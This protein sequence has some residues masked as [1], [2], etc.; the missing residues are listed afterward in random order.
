MKYK[1]TKIDDDTTELSYKDKKF[2]IKKDVE[3]LSKMESLPRRARIKMGSDLAK[4]GM[5]F[6]DLEVEKK[7]GNKT[8]IDKSTLI[9]TERMYQDLIANE[10]FSEIT[11]KYTNMSFIELLEDIEINV[12]ELG[13]DE[14]DQFI[15]EFLQSLRADNS[16]SE[17]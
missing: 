4:D 9:E 12:S 14:R 7:E 6:K 11:Q 16:P 17:K 3:L 5:T 8:Y 2:I 10:I 15:K 13:G 1:F